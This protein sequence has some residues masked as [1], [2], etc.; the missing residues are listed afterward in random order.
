[1]HLPNLPTNEILALRF[2]KEAL[3]IA[4]YIT[5]R[6]IISP[7]NI[8]AIDKDLR[9]YLSSCGRDIATVQIAISGLIEDNLVLAKK[10]YS[11]LT[12]DLLSTIVGEFWLWGSDACFAHSDFC[13][14]RDLFSN[15]PVYKAFMPLNGCSFYVIPGSHIQ[16]DRFARDIGQYVTSWDSSVGHTSVALSELYF[17]ADA[18]IVRL[19]NVKKLCDA[20]PLQVVPL[21]PGDIFLFNVNTV[22]GLGHSASSSG[23]HDFISFSVVNTPTLYRKYHFD[24]RLQMLEALIDTKVACSLEEIKDGRSSPESSQAI[25]P[26]KISNSVL[27]YLEASPKWNNSLGLSRISSHQVLTS[28]ARVDGFEQHILRK[29]LGS[30]Q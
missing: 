10:I 9:H 30:S 14:H 1:M 7:D 23:R 5:L 18:S 24:S 15:P 2:S 11:E 6:G 28:F 21:N 20:P 3:D 25:L 22:H 29:N 19:S 13:L 8:Q 17:S 27:D 16:T 4:G 26:P 12:Y